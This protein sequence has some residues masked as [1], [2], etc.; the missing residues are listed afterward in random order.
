MYVRNYT[1]KSI[2]EE[3][4]KKTVNCDFVCVGL[5]EVIDYTSLQI[6]FI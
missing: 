1:N 4:K 3:W 6:I 5:K 2:N